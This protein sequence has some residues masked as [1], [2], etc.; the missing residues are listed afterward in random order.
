MEDIRVSGSE[1]SLDF[2]GMAQSS[3]GIT[4]MFVMFTVILG[5]G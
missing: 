3:I 2:D 1:E 4:V 5:V